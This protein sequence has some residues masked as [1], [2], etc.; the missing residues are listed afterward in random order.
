MP[1]NVEIERRFLVDGRHERPWIDESSERIHVTQWYLDRNQM[2]VSENNEIIICSGE[3]LVSGIE[4]GIGH[5]I[6][7][8]PN[9]TVRIRKWNETYLLTLKGPRQGATAVE[10]EWQVDSHVATNVVQKSNTVCV[11]KNRYIL[12]SDDGRIWEVDEFEGHLSGLI[13][14]EVELEHEDSPILIP[15]WAGMELTHLD[16]WSNAALAKMLPQ[17]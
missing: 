5:S 2:T 14:A 9:W 3:V 1:E 12:K 7:I 11:E 16:G 6:K 4:A 8:E 10:Y 13:I 15:P 17:E